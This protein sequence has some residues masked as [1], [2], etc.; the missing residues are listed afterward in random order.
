MKVTY[1]QRFF[2]S[3]LWDQRQ[4]RPHYKKQWNCNVLAI[5]LIHVQVRRS[6]HLS[7]NQIYNSKAQGQ[8]AVL[9]YMWAELYIF[10]NAY[11]SIHGF[12]SHH[13]L[14]VIHWSSS[15][16]L[17][18]NGSFAVSIHC[19]WLPSIPWLQV[20]LLLLNSL[21]NIATWHKNTTGSDGILLTFPQ[22]PLLLY[23]Y[24]DLNSYSHVIDC[25]KHWHQSFCKCWTVDWT[26]DWTGWDWIGWD[27]IVSCQ[28][29]GDLS[30]ISC[31]TEL[32]W[33]VIWD[34]QSDRIRHNYIHMT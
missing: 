20:Y 5:M 4:K 21:L 8:H 6:Y 32:G 34:H 11:N 23:T 10:G 28:G 1:C 19:I 16:C 33:S 15:K 9:G 29:F 12:A 26:M 13:E 14:I 18:R 24:V 25:G 7:F 3:N 30:N 2:P 31:R 27:L 22:S 17:L